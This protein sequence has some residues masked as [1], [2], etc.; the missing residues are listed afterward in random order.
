MMEMEAPT[1]EDCMIVAHHLSGNCNRT[2]REAE[3]DAMARSLPSGLVF[4][5]STRCK[6][7]R[8]SN[9]SPPPSMKTHPEFR[10]PACEIVSRGC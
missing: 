1:V 3:R 9:L 2:G 5:L 6:F 4:V 8:R 10:I 7:V